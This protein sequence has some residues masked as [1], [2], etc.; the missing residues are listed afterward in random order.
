MIFILT[1]CKTEFSLAGLRVK[2]P[3]PV[4]NISLLHRPIIEVIEQAASGWSIRAPA[5]LPLAHTEVFEVVNWIQL[6]Q[7]NG[8]PVLSC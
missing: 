1:V 5:L 6:F 2:L 3:H 4:N 8:K 7:A